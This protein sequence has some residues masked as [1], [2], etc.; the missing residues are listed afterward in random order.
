LLIYF[1]KKNNI[2][3]EYQQVLVEIS[4]VLQARIILKFQSIERL[5]CLPEGH[6]E[7]Q[8]IDD[9]QHKNLSD[10]E[11]VWAYA[12]AIININTGGNYTIPEV[13]RM[14]RD[15]LLN[16]IMQGTKDGTKIGKGAKELSRRIG[17]SQPTI[18]YYVSLL[19]AE[20]ETQRLVGEGEMSG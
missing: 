19:K 16:L 5:T 1:F 8:L 20:P 15:A 13:K 7:R 18:W 10:I 4:I 9:A 17:V 6:L 3:D 2:F 11:R 12:T 14:E